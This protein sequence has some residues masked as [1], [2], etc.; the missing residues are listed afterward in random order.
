VKF[1]QLTPEVMLRVVDKFVVEVEKQ[2]A[3]KK[4]QIA[5]SP[6]ARQWLAEKGFDLLF[7]ARPL[8]RVIQTELKDKLATSSCGKLARGVPRTDAADGALTFL[9]QP[10]E[11]SGPSSRGA[12]PGRRSLPSSIPFPPRGTS[13]REPSADRHGHV[14]RAHGDRRREERDGSRRHV[15]RARVVHRLRVEDGCV[16]DARPARRGVV[17]RPAVPVVAVAMAAAVPVVG[18]RDRRQRQRKGAGK[19]EGAHELLHG[20]NASRSLEQ[21]RGGAVARTDSDV[22]GARC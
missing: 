12:A 7:G 17:G 21:H 13:E 8:A 3:E 5:L 9:C 4:V 16:D 10:R 6:A 15:D 11:P 22:T 19:S 18:R 1:K 2:L 20:L 14:G